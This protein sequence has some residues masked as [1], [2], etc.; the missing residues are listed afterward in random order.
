MCL[1]HVEK[2]YAFDSSQMPSQTHEVKTYKV[3]KFEI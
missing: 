1:F 2:D 3:I